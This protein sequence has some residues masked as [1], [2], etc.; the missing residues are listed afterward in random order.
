MGV[1]SANLNKDISSAN[2]S[3]V[4]NYIEDKYLKQ[5][6]EPNSDSVQSPIGKE[7]LQQPQKIAD[8]QISTKN[9]RDP[10]AQPAANVTETAQAGND[11]IISS[12]KNINQIV[13]ENSAPIKSN[14]TGRSP[15][16]E[17]DLHSISTLSPLGAQADK[18]VLPPEI[19]AKSEY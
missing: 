14:E 11:V 18:N 2:L 5:P 4:Q 6:Q 3:K 8:N 9:Q 1:S 13:L 7:R 15:S 12:G 10:L 19:S 16:Q 17:R